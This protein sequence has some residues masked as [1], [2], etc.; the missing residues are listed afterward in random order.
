MA[1][2]ENY[3]D[4]IAPTAGRKYNI[5]AEPDGSSKISDIT[6]YQ[7]TGDQ[8]GA[9]DIN[10][11]NA[12]INDFLDGTVG[13]K[14]ADTALACTGNA[15]TVG[16]NSTLA[17]GGAITTTPWLAAWEGKKVRCIA[18]T[19]VTVGNAD[20]FKGFDVGVSDAEA[21][22]ILRKNGKDYKYT[23]AIRA[24][25]AETCTGHAALDAYAPQ[26][27]TYNSQTGSETV[28]G[29]HF[30]YYPSGCNKNNCFV[31][32]VFAGEKQLTCDVVFSATDIAVHSYTATP[33]DYFMPTKVIV[34]RYK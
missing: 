27:A 4:F 20:H 11:T 23:D 17:Y 15:A 9:N 14:K 13:V 19:D 32:A 24:V 34:Q 8:F 21:Y 1:L 18:P 5:A 10:A 31:S 28:I 30:Y 26:E 6:Q 2:K 29:V 16:D 12:L 25:V 33:N 3:K 22:L 7:Q